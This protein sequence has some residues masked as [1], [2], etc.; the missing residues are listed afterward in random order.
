MG[1]GDFDAD[2]NQDLVVATLGL[3]KLVFLRG[4]E[5]GDFRPPEEVTLPGAVTAMTTGDINRRDGLQDIAVGVTGRNGFKL[6]ILEGTSGA[7]AATPEVLDLPAAASVLAVGQLDDDY[8]IDLAV[9]AGRQLIVIHGRDRKLSLDAVR[10]NEVKPAV[11]DRYPLGFEARSLAIG[12]FTGKERDQIAL[13]G[14]DGSTHVWDRATGRNPWTE[15]TNRLSS[16][17]GTTA[18]GILAVRAA[19][20]SCDNLVLLDS[21]SKRMGVFA[22][23]GRSTDSAAFEVEGGPIAALPMRLNSDGMQDLVILHKG[24][25]APMV[26]RSEAGGTFT[27]S[28]SAGGGPGSLQQA[29]LDANSSGQSANIVF[30]VPG[31]GVPFISP[32]GP[33]PTINV[34]VTI[35]GTTQ[36]PAGFVALDGGSA[37]A[38][39]NGFVLAGGNSLIRGLAI[40]DF[41]AAFDSQGGITGGFGV[42]LTGGGNYTIED[43]SIGADFSGEAARGNGLGIAI[44]SNNNLIGGTAQGSGN[45]ISGNTLDGIVVGSRLNNVITGNFVGTDVRGVSAL[46]N[47][48]EGV[49]LNG[50]TNSTVS[51]NLLSGNQLA[52]LVMFSAPSTGN[53]VEGNYIGT[54]ITGML[55]VPNQ[56]LGL[57]VTLAPGNTVTANLISGN[58][59]G[60]VAIGNIFMDLFGD[61]S[62]LVKGNFI[63]VDATHAAPLPNTGHG[64][65]VE[66]DSIDNQVVGN[67]IAFNLGAG[68]RIPDDPSNP[69]ITKKPAVQITASSNLIHSNTGLGIDLGQLGPTPNPHNLLDGANHLQNFPELSS[70]MVSGTLRRLAP[71]AA[72]ITVSGTLSA[73]ANTTYALEFF[74]GGACDSS[75]GGHQFVGTI[76]VLLG[77]GNASTDGAGNASYTFTFPVP[78]TSKV[79]NGFVNATATDPVGNTSEF[80]LCAPVSGA[81]PVGPVINSVQAAGKNL[82]VTGQNFDQGAVI[83][84]N[85]DPQRTLH[86]DQNPST[87][88]IGKKA[89]KNIAPGETVTIQVQNSDGSLSNQV[90]YTRPSG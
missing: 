79:S 50:S 15:V 49:I 48:E 2:G 39:A 13:V 85:G 59:L 57:L 75:Q 24:H 8:P 23:D 63:G 62:T 67:L 14:D 72:T 76:P 37:G 7:M 87:S 66:N 10:Q 6:L 68:V 40:G 73:S 42:S 51:G 27:V 3:N 35:D 21:L 84:K 60:G 33:L 30:N 69:S 12:D 4:T 88:L 41:S 32:G 65:F 34:P 38:G 81:I 18:T 61:S 64:V 5:T 70:A 1:I 89:N 54:D 58:E 53:L 43:C 22:L 9:A 82:V 16:L 83:L 47:A 25:V 71:A 90:T 55:A 52:G 80:S 17:S 20:A 77:S 36:R 44:T 19:A 46:P 31:T 28:N 26:I 29:I 86:D 74:L 11:V 56:N 45:L 78:A